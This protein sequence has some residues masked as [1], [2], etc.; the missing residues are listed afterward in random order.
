MLCVYMTQRF[1]VIPAVYLVLQR[2]HEV[3]LIRRANT[4]YRDGEYSL[5]AGHHDGGESL[6]SAMVREAKEEIGI[7]VHE[8]DLQLAHVMHRKADDGE[9]VDFYFTCDKWLGDVANCEP[10]K[11]DELR[12][13]SPQELPEN[14]IP[15][16]RQ[17]LRAIANTIPFST[18]NWD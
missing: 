11:C 7:D 13:T 6:R 8:M 18:Q 12:W 5:P 15:E 14:T 16:V 1:T 2:A 4:G 9:R 10:E 3:L 17:A